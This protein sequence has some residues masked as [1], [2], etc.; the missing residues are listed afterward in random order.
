VAN[1]DEIVLSAFRFLSSFP[2]LDGATTVL[3]V[4]M[5]ITLTYGN[6]SNQSAHDCCRIAHAWR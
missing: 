6:K 2:E 3:P 1:N 5:M 4:P